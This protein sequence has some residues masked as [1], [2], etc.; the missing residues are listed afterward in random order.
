MSTAARRVRSSPIN[1][2]LGV[3]DNGCPIP[4]RAPPGLPLH[5]PSPSAG[6]PETGVKRSGPQVSVD[7]VDRVNCARRSR[8][9]TMWDGRG[10][11]RQRRCGLYIA[12]IACTG[13]NPVPATLSLSCGNAAADRLIRGVS[14][15]RFPSTRRPAD[16]GCLVRDD[17]LN[18][19]PRCDHAVPDKPGRCPARAPPHRCST[20][21]WRVADAI[22]SPN[23]GVRPEDRLQH[24][25]ASGLTKPGITTSAPPRPRQPRRR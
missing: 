4:V 14:T 13:S 3:V 12:G 10:H 16:T 5:L 20:A 22:G 19:E 8:Y 7:V 11:A 25:L 15:L 9:R 24:Q 6:P 2:N 1:L 17:S 18:L 23:H 21:R